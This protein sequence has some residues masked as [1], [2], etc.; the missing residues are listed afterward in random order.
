MTAASTILFYHLRVDG[1][2]REMWPV[3]GREFRG[4]VGWKL[5][6]RA[7]ETLMKNSATPTNEET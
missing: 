3:E 4:S 2:G 1:T 5:Q 7:A 6:K